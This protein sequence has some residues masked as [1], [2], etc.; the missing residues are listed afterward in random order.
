MSYFDGS[1]RWVTQE[2][3]FGGAGYSLSPITGI[4]GSAIPVGVDPYAVPLPESR[5]SYVTLRVAEAGEQRVDLALPVRLGGWYADEIRDC[6]EIVSEAT[7]GSA[8]YVHLPDVSTAGMKAVERLSR[9]WD[10]SIS[11]I[12][13]LRSNEGGPYA[14]YLSGLLQNLVCRSSVMIRG[15]ARTILLGGPRKGIVLINERTG[16]GGE[17]LAAALSRSPYFT[18]AGSRTFGAGTG[19]TR[20]HK[21][22]A[23]LVMTVPEFELRNSAKD[24]GIEN[25]GVEPDIAISRSPEHQRPLANA[26]L[27][28]AARLVNEDDYHGPIP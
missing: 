2:P 15:N 16:S 13:D 28:S 4:N 7:R 27:I 3:S 26:D 1:R 22:S 10:E 20:T 17:N 21:L 9:G 8:Q 5:H 18:L 23:G 19:F 25:R 11:V 12:V 14:D 24:A 6:C